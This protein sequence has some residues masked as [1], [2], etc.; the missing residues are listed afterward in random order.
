MIKITKEKFLAYEDVR[1]SGITNMYHVDY[2]SELSGL[3][4]D[5]IRDIM[6]NYS[7]YKEEFM[8][9]G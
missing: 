4:K 6:V 8:P 3:N 1:A 2:V 7:K 5:E 9:N